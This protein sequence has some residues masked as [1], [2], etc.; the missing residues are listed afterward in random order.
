MSPEVVARL[1][2]SVLLLVSVLLQT[3]VVTDVRLRGSCADLMLLFAICAGLAGGAE[4]GAISGFAAGLLIDLFLHSTPVGLSALTYCLVGFGVG[5][6]RRAV[7]REGWLLPPAIA[8]VASS[9]GVILFVMIGSVVGQS[10]LTAIGPRTIIQI[11]VI[12]GVMNAVLA[13]PVSHLVAWAA[14]GSAGANRV[15]AEGP[16]LLK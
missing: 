15:R 5:A 12:V 6:V 1:R 14:T 16:A 11:A 9:S 7:F 10:Q 8:L 3:T 4:M 2:L 13:V